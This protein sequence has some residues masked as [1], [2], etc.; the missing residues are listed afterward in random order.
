MF[1]PKCGNN[2]GEGAAFCSR[3]GYQIPQ[4]QAQPAPQAAPQQTYGGWNNEP[5]P[6]AAPQQT[7]G[8]WNNEPAPQAAPQQTY[9]GW[10]SEPAPQYGQPA[11]G[12]MNGGAFA[13]QPVKDKCFSTGS[14]VTII[15][16]SSLAMINGIISRVSWEA[17]FWNIFVYSI[18]PVLFMIAAVILINKVPPVVAIAPFGYGLLLETVDLFRNLDWYGTGEYLLYFSYLSLAVMF[19][20]Q[21]LTRKKVFKVFAVIL[22]FLLAFH[23]FFAGFGDVIDMLDWYGLDIF[24]EF[25]DSQYVLWIICDQAYAFYWGLAMILLVFGVKS[26]KQQ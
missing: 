14:M 20:F 6:Q 16:F 18:L 2:I 8:G 15:I 26:R 5:A 12:G 3:C 10:N 21:L 17:S 9:G 23:R 7:Y 13:A 19:L 4:T 25:F 24:E 11:F 1:C 22:A